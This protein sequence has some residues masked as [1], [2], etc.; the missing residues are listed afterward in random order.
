MQS[1]LYGNASANVASKWAT[2]AQG[3]AALADGNWA[4]VHDD[5]ARQIQDLGLSFRMMGIR[6]TQ[7]AAQSPCRSSLA[8]A[9]GTQSPALSSAPTCLAK[10]DR[11]YAGEQRLVGEGH[12]PASLI[13]GSR[14]F[15]RSMIGVA[16]K[17]G[18]I[19]MSI[20]L[21]SRVGRMERGAYWRPG[22][23]REWHRLCTGK[24]AGPV[25]QHWLVVVN[26]HT[27]RLADFYSRLRAGI[28]ADCDRDDPRIALLTPG[29]FNQSYPEQ[30]HLARY[31]GFPLVEGR[32]LTV[33]NDVSRPHNRRPQTY[34]CDLALDQYA[35]PRSARI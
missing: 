24:P 18:I 28:A 3:L 17:A 32:D 25:A 4:R 16:P 20:P 26:I 19:S 30:A 6:M 15:Q 22:Q 5:V 13:T 1:D 27:R 9:N 21:I 2:M 34:R 11:R 14:N 10:S 8:P 31:L 29:R 12:M 33:S 7:L 35:A 23:F